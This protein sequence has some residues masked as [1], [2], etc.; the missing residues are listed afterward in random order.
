MKQKNMTEQLQKLAKSYTPEWSFSAQNPDAGSVLGILLTD[1]LRGSQ[2]RLDQAM[3]KHKVQYLNRFDR[4]VEE[5]VS[6]ARG[7]VQFLPVTGNEDIMA[8]PAQTGLSA[9][10]GEKEILFETAYDICLADTGV[11]SVIVT[12]QKEDKIV[13]LAQ[14]EDQSRLEHLDFQAFDIRGVNEASHVFYLCLSSVVEGAQSV[15]LS[16]RLHAQ[17]KEDAVNAAALLASEQVRISMAEPWGEEGGYREVGFDQVTCRENVLSLKKEGYSIQ[18]AEIDGKEGYFL[19]FKAVKGIPQIVLSGVDICLSG[20]DIAP[21]LVYLEGVDVGSRQFAPFGIPLE[22]MAECSMDSREVFSKKGAL[23]TMDF[24]LEY[25]IR[26]EKIEMQE[27]EIEYKAIMKRPPEAALSRTVTVC[28]DRISWEY[29][30][31][32]GWKRLLTGGEYE[33]LMNGEKQGKIRLSFPCPEDMAD[34][35]EDEP[36]IR[37]RLLFAEN[38]YK[39]PALYKCPVIK[40]LQFSYDYKENPVKPL[41]GFSVN[42]CQKR[43]CMERFM[44]GVDTGI[45]Y[46]TQGQNRCMY[47]C[48]D[49]PI[50]GLPFSLF[51]DI[52]NLNGL[53]VSFTAEYLSENGFKTLRVIDETDGFL[54]SGVIR[55][56]ISSD[57]KREALFGREGYFLRFTGFEK[58]YPAYRL[59]CIRGIYPNMAR[60]ENQNTRTEYFYVED[61]NEPLTIKLAEENLTQAFVSVHEKDKEGEGW[62]DWKKAVRSYEAGRVYQ[63]DLAAG[64]ITFSAFAFS[65]VS[66]AQEGPQIRVCY[67]SYKGD[68]ANLPA[69]AIVTMLDANRY[70]SEVVNPF[71]TYGGCDAYT[72]ESTAGY[73]EGILK[74]RNRIVTQQDLLKVLRQTSYSIL[75]TSCM[76][77]VDEQGNPAPGLMT[78]AVL[79]QDIDRTGNV[80]FDI[81]KEMMKKLEET[82]NFR[83]MGRTVNLV[84][85]RFLACSVTVWLEKDNMENVYELTKRAQELIHDFLDPFCGGIGQ[86]GWRIGS[87]PRVSQIRA[88]LEKNLTEV[89]IA[90]IA[91]TAF[92]DGQEKKIREDISDLSKSP[93]VM[94]V[95]GQ[96][97]VY[98]DLKQ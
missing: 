89:T 28:A 9:Q 21:D 79:T 17:K 86:K 23:V 37:I 75:E 66:F 78:A 69:G 80:F 13:T 48:F 46:P 20:N 85:P 77:D 5:P 11:T 22:M 96:H 73:I 42:N 88:W 51:F 67:R 44:A 54:H 19:I 84:Q 76:P 30:S 65:E 47:F 49:N 98:I 56:L 58:E 40:N 31:E 57:M 87:Y 7:Y 53:P 41:D 95:N 62:K 74:S 18:P 16:L 1:M 82:G 39:M 45:F 32:N 35:E 60:V 83:I 50:W 59:P 29:R 91:V 27:P 94:P 70:V 15:D 63:E 61:K 6:A 55:F 3:H 12:D 90:Q 64:T 2:N 36:R 71:A 14:K 26:E 24:D 81:R 52:E 38:I 33:K 34:W 93:F 72:E 4:L 25:E 92:V 10:V 68:E 8:V 43:S 97:K